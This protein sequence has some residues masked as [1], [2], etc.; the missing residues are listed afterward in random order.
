MNYLVTHLRMNPWAMQ[1][2][3]HALSLHAQ[4]PIRILDL[5]KARSLFKKW[6]KSI[7][8]L[9]DSTLLNRMSP[10]LIKYFWFLANVCG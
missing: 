6:S 2:M 8:R 5:A 9:D 7:G 10:R 3:Q 1:V 4:V